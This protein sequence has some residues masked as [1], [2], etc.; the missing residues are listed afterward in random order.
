M[1][2]VGGKQLQGA[3]LN[4]HQTIAVQA[5]PVPAADRWATPFLPTVQV[6]GFANLIDLS[7]CTGTFR[8]TRA[9]QG[10]RTSTAAFPP[11]PSPVAEAM[12]QAC[13]RQYRHSAEPVLFHM[14]DCRIIDLRDT[15]LAYRTDGARVEELLL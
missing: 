15:L 14:V 5:D 4:T 13:I 6:I 8:A 3:V 11:W 12:S 10:G 1:P 2:E 7:A 9:G